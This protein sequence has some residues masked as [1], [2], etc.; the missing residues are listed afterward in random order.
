MNTFFKIIKLLFPLI[1]FASVSAG[2]AKPDFN[3]GEFNL[4][5]H[6]SSGLNYTY[7][8]N[9]TVAGIYKKNSIPVLSGF[10]LV[11]KN[12]F[13]LELTGGYFPVM[14]YS[15]VLQYKKTEVTV[16]ASLLAFPVTLSLKYYFNQFSISAGASFCILN[17]DINLSNSGTY[18]VHNSFGYLAAVAYEF[19]L[20]K[21][22]KFSPRVSFYKIPEIGSSTISFQIRILFDLLD[23]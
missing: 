2:Q 23:F 7:E 10:D 17:S 9:T 22:F 18:A 14:F 16:A 6:L 21:N 11:F 4:R 5:V 3:P 12:T 15:N 19:N 13:G 1:V 8:S 20:F